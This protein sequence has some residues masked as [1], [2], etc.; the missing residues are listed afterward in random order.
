MVFF[1][2]GPSEASRLSLHTGDYMTF[3]GT[4]NQQLPLVF[5]KDYRHIVSQTSRNMGYFKITVIENSTAVS[6]FSL[7][8]QVVIFINM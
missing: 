3:T 1:T 5:T 6:Y 4:M 2:L 8:C 7:A